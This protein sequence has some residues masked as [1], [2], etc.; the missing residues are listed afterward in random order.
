MIKNA[1]IGLLT[2]RII[3][4]FDFDADYIMWKIS[5]YAQMFVK[6]FPMILSV[7]KFKVTK[8]RNTMSKSI[9]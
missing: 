2:N 5:N 3:V 9:Q 6:V 8:T 1:I 7:S 4:T